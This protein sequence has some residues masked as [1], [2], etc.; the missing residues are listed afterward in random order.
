MIKIEI[1]GRR[2]YRLEHLLLDV[3][4]TIAQDGRLLEGV[5]VQVDALRPVLQVHMLTADTHGR[6]QRIDARLGL[7]AT[8]IT[9]GQEAAQKAA[10]VR[11]LGRRH[12][13]AI[14]NGANDAR[15][16]D[17]AAIAIAVLGPEGLALETLT[18]ADVVTRDIHDALDLLLHPVR[19]VAT[20]RR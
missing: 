9:P 11:E 15:M 13:C 8:R 4:G 10:L 16:L 17:E 19:L 14:G 6:Q 18:A 2:I 7:R 20:L 12:V 3:N 5:A 1:P